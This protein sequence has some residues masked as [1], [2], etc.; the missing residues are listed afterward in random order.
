MCDTGGPITCGI[1]NASSD[2]LSAIADSFGKAAGWAIKEMTT[3]WLGVPSPNLTAPGSA[4]SWLSSQLAWAVGIAALC[5][6]LFAAYRM[7]TTGQFSHGADLGAS[8]FRLV[9]VMG[10]ITFITELLLGAGDAYSLWMVRNTPAPSSTVLGLAFNPVGQA[11][12]NAVPGPGD[13]A[14]GGGAAGSGDPAS[15]DA[16][17]KRDGGVADRIPPVDRS[18]I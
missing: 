10:S 16:A 17:E 14:R 4:A 7:A 8:L 9:V 11:T 1:Q 5:S 6:V 3:A 2:V 13:S 18:G 12:G 15:S